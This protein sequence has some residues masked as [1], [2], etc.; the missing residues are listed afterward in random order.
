MARLLLVEDDADLLELQALVL[1]GAGHEV[2]SAQ[3]PRDALEAF[4]AR[5]PDLVIM[6]Y[7]LPRPEDGAALLRDLGPDARVLVLSGGALN[8]DV[9]G[10]VRAL[11]KPCAPRVLLQAISELL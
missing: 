10:A 3:S 1:R 2:V 11:R 4:R 9:E 8:G 5:Q 7:R 6:D